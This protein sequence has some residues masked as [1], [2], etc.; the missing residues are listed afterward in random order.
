MR[1][2]DLRKQ[3]PYF[4]FPDRYAVFKG[5][6][7]NWYE[8]I[9]TANETTS[10]TTNSMIDDGTSTTGWSIRMYSRTVYVFAILNLEEKLITDRHEF[11][12]SDV[13]K[14]IFSLFEEK[15]QINNVEDIYQL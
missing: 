4:L 15:K 13:K 3:I 2:E 5:K 9:D 11:E 14:R 12:Y 6:E 8:I 10:I 7:T 1:P